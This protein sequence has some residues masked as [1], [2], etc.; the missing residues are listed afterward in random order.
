MEHEDETFSY[1]LSNGLS[2]LKYWIPWIETSLINS[3]IFAE[4]SF[5]FTVIST[6][7]GCLCFGQNNIKCRCPTSLKGLKPFFKPFQKILVPFLE[8]FWTPASQPVPKKGLKSTERVKANKS[9]RVLASYCPPT[10][11]LLSPHRHFGI[12]CSLCLWGRPLMIWSEGWRKSREKNLKMLL[13]EK[14]PQRPY[15]RKKKLKLSLRGRTFSSEKK[16]SW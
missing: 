10:T 12:I 3:L 9:S 16:I 2:A 11:P 1:L 15:S 5:L 6:R 7:W 4:V 8:W 14:K 13:R